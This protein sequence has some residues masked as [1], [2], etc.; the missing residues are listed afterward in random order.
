MSLEITIYT[1]HATKQKL[2][3]EL[4]LHGFQKSES[5]FELSNEDRGFMW[6]ETK[7]YESFVGVEA[8]VR[9]SSEEEKEKYSCSEWILHT[10]TRSSGSQ[11]D[12][13]KQNIIVKHIRK[14]FGGTFYND[15]YGT[16]NYTKLTGYPELTASE[17]GLVLMKENLENKI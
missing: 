7:N 4:L 11:K 13:E 2:I 5:I 15:W 8:T 3:N 1:K 9:K 16:N 10:R 17:R 14:L 6:F 12:K